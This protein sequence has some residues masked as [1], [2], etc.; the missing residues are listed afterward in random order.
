MDINSCVITGRFWNDI[1]QS[2]L[3]ETTAGKHAINFK[4][5]C[6]KENAYGEYDYIDCSAFGNIAKNIYKYCFKYMS[7]TIEGRICS[8]VY[9]TNGEKNYRMFLLVKK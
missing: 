8:E 7:V 6:S 2:S 5:A 3:K 1:D 9:E 4:V